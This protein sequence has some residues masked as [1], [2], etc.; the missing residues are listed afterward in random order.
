MRDARGL[1]LHRSVGAVA[2]RALPRHGAATAAAAA[3]LAAA[4]MLLAGCAGS[5]S[6]PVSVALSEA[7]GYPA[8]APVPDPLITGGDLSPFGWLS[9]DRSTITIIT[10]GSS[11]CPFIGTAITL[12]DPALV[13]IEFEQ[14]RAQ[15]CTEDLGSRTHVFAAP[16]GVGLDG[17]EAELSIAANAYD[18]TEPTVTVVTLWPAPSAAESI[19]IETIRGVPEGI[20]LPDDAL[21]LG[22]PLVYWGSGRETLL[23]V[24]WG[25][26]SCPPIPLELAAA[27]PDLLTLRFGPHPSEAC[28]ADFGPTTH[29]LPTPVGVAAGPVTLEVTLGQAD[30]TASTSKIPIRD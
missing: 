24:T 15:A 8:N 26:S 14:A 22:Q 20:A 17:L 29:V 13:R 6:A 7:S 1:Q 18:D 30:G 3:S 21:D 12:I 16:T 5:S 23:V 4:M 11:S 28:T 27:A 2:S 10:Y 9:D 25:S 19:A